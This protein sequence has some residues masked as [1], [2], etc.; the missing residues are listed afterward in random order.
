LSKSCVASLAAERGDRE[1]RAFRIGA[2]AAEQRLPHLHSE[3]R[4]VRRREQRKKTV[5]HV[6]RD[7]RGSRCCRAVLEQLAERERRGEVGVRWRDLTGRRAG[8]KGG[9]RIAM[10]ALAC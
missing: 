6:T 2:A 7:R 9:D 10:M 1:L 5:R 4:D 8:E 3:G